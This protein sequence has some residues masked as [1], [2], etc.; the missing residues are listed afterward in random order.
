MNN[1]PKNIKKWLNNRGI[2]DNAIINNGL[3]WNG[4]AIVIPIY[5]EHGKFSFNKYRKDPLSDNDHPK[6]WY[7]KGTTATLY[8]AHKIS[9]AW[10]DWSWEMVIICEGE[11]DCLVLENIG[12]TA[13]SST[14]GSGTFK[15]EWTPLFEKVNRIYVCYDNDE[16]GHRGAVKVL[17]KIP[18]AYWITLLSLVKEH[19]DITDFLKNGGNIIS[20]M[21]NAK[22]YPVFKLK[23]PEE[24]KTI[25]ECKNWIVKYDEESKILWELIWKEKQEHLKYITTTIENRIDE[26]KR[27]I[28]KIRYKKNKDDIFNHP[29]N[30]S[31]NIIER[32]I[33]AA[34]Q[35]PITNF[36]HGKL[37]KSGNR[38]TGL[39]PFHSEKT[40]SF[41]IYLKQNTFFCFGC[42]ASR[43]VIDYV[44]KER[45]CDFLSAV[46]IILNI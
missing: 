15:E 30:G 33:E 24:I 13:V 40:N 16:A 45:E 18:S 27:L 42:S 25:K 28:K 23:E 14:G 21:E 17:S 44:M 35:V 9:E 6:Y 7:D 38:V 2:T 11:M 34:K 43:D 3:Y 12:I 37:T 19:G 46:K 31:E 29:I 32:H 4:K 10:K 36:Y 8:N 26:L 22:N 5:D 39:C 41:V 20:L 1:L